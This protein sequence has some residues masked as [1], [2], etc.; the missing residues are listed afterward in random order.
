[1]S[2][3]RT[4][5]AWWQLCT[6]RH[7]ITEYITSRDNRVHYVTRWHFSDLR[8]QRA[9]QQG[10]ALRML[11]SPQQ[12]VNIKTGKTSVRSVRAEVRAQFPTF[13]RPDLVVPV[14]VISLSF[15]C[16]QVVG[17]RLS[18]R[19]VGTGFFYIFY[20]GHRLAVRSTASFICPSGLVFIRN[21]QEQYTCAINRFAEWL[22]ERVIDRSIHLY[23]WWINSLM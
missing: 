23:G 12:K 10:S 11:N 16:G 20:L 6:L 15:F 3:R 4:W 14:K 1:M 13:L 19:P 8:W 7:E 22:I 2:S 18:C 5:L 21:H 9:D 17:R